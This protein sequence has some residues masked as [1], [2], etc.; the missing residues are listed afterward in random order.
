[1]SGQDA[2]TVDRAAELRHLFDAAFARVPATE[3][4]QLE[5]LL[6]VRVGPNPYALR[7]TEI[8]ALVVDASIAGLPDPA[9]ALVG[10]TSLRGTSVVVYDLRVLLGYEGGE[11]SRWLVLTAT[12]ATVGLAFDE[13][14]GHLRVPRDAVA[15]EEGP[16]PPPSRAQEI[17]RLAEVVRPIVR[18]PSLLDAITMRVRHGTAQKER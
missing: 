18:I 12:D 17:V 2:H 13:F 16:G 15:V 1:V 7:L 3:D 11:P 5:D 8:S 4:T 10:I 6:A 9:P 14:E